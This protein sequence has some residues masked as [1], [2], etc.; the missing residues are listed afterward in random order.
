MYGLAVLSFDSDYSLPYDNLD[1]A[2]L[3]QYD[4][5][6]S[7]LLLWYVHSKLISRFPLL[8]LDKCDAQTKVKIAIYFQFLQ[9]HPNTNRLVMEILQKFPELD[10]S[11]NELGYTSSI[12]LQISNVLQEE[13]NKVQE[14][15]F[16]VKNEFDGLQ[17]VF[18]MDIAVFSENMPIAFVEVDGNFHYQIPSKLDEL[19]RKDRL[20]EMIYM[21][22]FPNVKFYRIPLHKSMK[23]VSAIGERLASKI[24]LAQSQKALCSTRKS[25]SNIP[26]AFQTKKSY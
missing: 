15:T 7:T 16:L 14:G 10:L 5:F 3:T 13:L 2:I 21:N 18:P 8:S 20:K 17:G 11:K 12:H 19:R 26:S 1:P 22:K 4:N 24:L 23:D 6:E 25:T 9:S